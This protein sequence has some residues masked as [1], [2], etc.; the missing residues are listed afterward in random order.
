[1][2]ETRLTGQQI[3]PDHGAYLGYGAYLGELREARVACAIESA[4]GMPD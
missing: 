2:R 1:M 3:L 4:V